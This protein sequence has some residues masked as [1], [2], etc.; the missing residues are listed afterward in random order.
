M[1]KSIYQKGETITV[2]V[3][4]LNKTSQNINVSTFSFL[5][6]SLNLNLRLPNG[7][8]LTHTVFTLDSIPPEI[9]IGPGSSIKQEIAITNDIWYEIFAQMYSQPFQNA[10][11]YS[12]KVIYRS[13]TP[14]IFNLMEEKNII[15]E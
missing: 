4:L 8:I 11:D 1:N 2:V 6:E 3:E 7:I 10:G 13:F 12:L 14:H 5:Y 9:S 15:I